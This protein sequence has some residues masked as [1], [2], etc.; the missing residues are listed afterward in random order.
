MSSKV[1]DTYILTPVCNNQLYNF[2]V[3]ALKHDTINFP[4]RPHPITIVWTQGKGMFKNSFLTETI[5]NEGMVKAFIQEKI[6]E[7][8]K[9]SGAQIV[10]DLQKSMGWQT[11]GKTN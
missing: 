4:N 9:K 2:L 6:T 10:Y 7:I 11:I 1:E 3:E 5:Y 8:N